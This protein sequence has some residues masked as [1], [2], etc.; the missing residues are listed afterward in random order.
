MRQFT[1][2]EL[3]RLWQNIL[4]E[5]ISED[6]TL[7]VV[8]T[9]SRTVN[10]GE[11]FV[12]V[13][14]ENFDAHQFIASAVERGANAVVVEKK[15]DNLSVPQIVVNNTR[16][17][18]AVLAKSIRQHFTGTVIGLTGSVGKT[19]N[20]QM[21]A[22][23]LSQVGKTHATQGN[24]NN[25]LGVPFTWFAL[26]DDAQYAVIEMGANHQGEIAYLAQM[27]RPNIAMITNA[28]P[29]HLAGFGGLDGV[30]KGKGEV[31]AGLS[32]G[33][34]A[35]I[36]RDD[37]YHAYWQGLVKTDVNVLTFALRDKTA[38]IYAKAISADGSH[39]TLCYRG[40]EQAV[41]LPTVGQHNV[42]NALGVSACAIAAGV[43]LSDIAKGLAVFETAEGRLQKHR[44]G[45]VTIID[46]TYN[47]N[48]LSMRASADIL[49]G[50]RGYRVMV[51][52]DM[53]ELGEDELALH[54]RLGLDLEKK[55]DAFFCFGD[56]MR[57]FA[58]NNRLARHFD[59]LSTLCAAV[60]HTLSTHP[61]ATVLIKGSRSMQMERVATYLLNTLT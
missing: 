20:K 26:S 46:D 50:S 21:L 38:D 35:I 44:R 61:A 47:A 17:A 40:Q 57:L 14:G 8:N 1:T 3:N 42:M 48:P 29:A 59:D 37:N 43:A 18:L 31:F 15:Q 28:G 54:A 60:L 58:E 24:L 49:A 12:V 2:A 27:T 33:D 55:A 5:P 32:A 16:L 30:A 51:I 34:T 9:D 56:K 6:V 39:F 11:T 53:G 36:N 4:L 13:S 52:G 45:A 10:A 19:T 25:D 23:V 7:S 41:T 22:S